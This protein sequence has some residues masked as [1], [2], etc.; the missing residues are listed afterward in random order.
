MTRLDIAEKYNNLNYSFARSVFSN[1]NVLYTDIQPMLATPNFT[2]NYNDGTNAPSYDVAPNWL[3]PSWFPMDR[4][5]QYQLGLL[6][7]TPNV[8]STYDNL[9]KDYEEE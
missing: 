9:M 8:L 1:P 2:V 3:P 6:G 5:D 7:S 4:Y